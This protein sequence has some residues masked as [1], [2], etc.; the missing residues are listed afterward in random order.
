MSS[1]GFLIVHQNFETKLIIYTGNFGLTLASILTIYTGYIYF[2]KNLK[3]FK[4]KK[5]MELLVGVEV[6]KLTWLAE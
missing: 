3:F 6:E 1:L 5:L 2:K 4:W